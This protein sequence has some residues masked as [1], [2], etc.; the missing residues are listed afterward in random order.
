VV[1]R[2][3]TQPGNHKTSQVSK[4]KKARSQGIVRDFL[5]NAR[6]CPPCPRTKLPTKKQNPKARH[7]AGASGVGVDCAHLGGAG[8]QAPALMKNMPHWKRGAL[9]GN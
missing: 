3:I 2:L 6:A 1:E 9:L 7:S 8:E 5:Q 4:K